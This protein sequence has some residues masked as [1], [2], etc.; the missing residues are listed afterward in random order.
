[1]PGLLILS[2]KGPGFSSLALEFAKQ[3]A[4]QICGL[5]GQSRPDSDGTRAGG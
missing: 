2:A 5:G 3:R 4:R 1:M